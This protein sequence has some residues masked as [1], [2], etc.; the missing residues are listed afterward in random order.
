MHV[1]SGRCVIASPRARALVS[2]RC[3]ARLPVPRHQFCN[4]FVRCM[5]TSKPNISLFKGQ[6]ASRRR[7]LLTRLACSNR[8]LDRPNTSNKI[9]QWILSSSQLKGNL[10]LNSPE[11]T[12]QMLL[13][14][15]RSSI[16]KDSSP[17]RT[18]MIKPF[19]PSSKHIA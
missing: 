8:Q 12:A 13:K 4:H 3:E 9:H 10:L 11:N 18:S 1:V 19:K 17:R 16:L 15:L 7:L 5:V 2:C 14:Q 6:R